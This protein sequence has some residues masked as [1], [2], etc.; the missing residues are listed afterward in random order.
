[1]QKIMVDYIW[2]LTENEGS[3]KAEMLWLRRNVKS[4]EI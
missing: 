1:M 3:Y 2:L 4:V